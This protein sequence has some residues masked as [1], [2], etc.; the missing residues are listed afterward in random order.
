MM[1][2]LLLETYGFG[3]LFINRPSLS[4]SIYSANPWNRASRRAVT[5]LV[6]GRGVV[7]ARGLRRSQRRGSWHNGLRGEGVPLG[8]G[9]GEERLPVGVGL[10]RDVA[11]LV[12]VSASSTLVGLHQDVTGVDGVQSMNCFEEE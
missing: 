2:D 4:L 10:G 12:G 6:V 7:W 5:P 11:E 3:A 1:L 8:Y 9:A